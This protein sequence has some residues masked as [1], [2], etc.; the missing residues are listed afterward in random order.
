MS[1]NNSNWQITT[2]QGNTTITPQWI[3]DAEKNASRIQRVR[4]LARKFEQET[5]DTNI[6][7]LVAY[8]I[9]SALDGEQE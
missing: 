4:E 3:I 8:R 5:D 7:R 6:Y 2:E 1:S 9:Y